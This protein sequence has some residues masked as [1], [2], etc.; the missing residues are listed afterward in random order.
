[1]R[2]RTRVGAIRILNYASNHVVNRIPSYTL[3]HLWYRRAIGIDLAPDA[4][5]QLGLRLWFLGPRQVRRSV[6]HIGARVRINRDCEL[7][8][9]AG[10]LIGDDVSI[11]PEVVILTTD[12]DL[13]TPGFPL[14]HRAV[15]IEDHVW[16]GMRAMLLPGV[17]VGRG[18]VVAA[19][20]V[21]TRDVPPLCVVAGMPARPIGTRDVRGLDY[22]LDHPVA[23]FE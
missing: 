7:D 3:R 1:L 2:S 14:R 15:V 12:H 19:G 18:A 5:V 10:L 11:S 9:R 16:I 22:A 4:S 23:L 20:A 13:D 6:V 17:H 21:V 8:V